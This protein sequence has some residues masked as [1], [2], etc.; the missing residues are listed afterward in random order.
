TDAADMAHLL[1][2]VATSRDLSAS[3]RGELVGMLANTPPPDALRDNPPDD[4][5][6]VDKTGNLDDASNIA[7][8]L[9]STR[10]TL[11]LTVLD[12]GVDPGDA[13]GLIARLGEFAFQTLAQ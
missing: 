1:R 3:S 11:L 9:Q 12:Q 2:L 5:D 6:I 10:G 4:V 13:R 8:L 7:A